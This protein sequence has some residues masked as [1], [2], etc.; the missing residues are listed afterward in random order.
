MLDFFRKLWMDA[1]NNLDFGLD[2]ADVGS[3]VIDVSFGGSRDDSL[4][5]S[6]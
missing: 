1:Y 5:A 6:P 2:L 4:Y 3:G